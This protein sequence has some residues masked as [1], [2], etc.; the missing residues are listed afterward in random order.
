MLSCD[1]SAMGADAYRMEASGA[2]YLHLDVMDGSFV[3]KISF[4]ADIIKSLREKTKLF[5][6]VH[7]MIERPE[8]HASDFA[9]AG[10]NLIT[11]HAEASNHLQ[12]T[13]RLIKDFGIR[14]GVALNPATPI[15]HVKYVLD[16]IDLL[17]I[18]TVN[19]GYGGQ[20]LIP[21]TVGKIA[22][23][24]EMITRSGRK[25]E[26]EVDGGINGI[27]RSSCAARARMCLF[28]A[29]MYLRRRTQVKPWT[30]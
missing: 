13:L 8:L 1:Y 17:L 3:P 4:G 7:L 6:D 27:L 2:D 9:A 10:A 20:K 19:P 14:A 25:I 21:A 23:A 26:L 29:V 15:E 5:F 24:N 30:G 11:V 12:R 16:D 28:P 22:D 18:M